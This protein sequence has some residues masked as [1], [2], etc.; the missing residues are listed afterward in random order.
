MVTPSPL[1]KF[2]WEPTTYLRRFLWA[3]PLSKEIP[4]TPPPLTPFPLS[5]K[6][7]IGMLIGI[8]RGT[9][10]LS[11]EIPMPPSRPTP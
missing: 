3:F 5:K 6:I 8:P 9:P 11:K 4:I 2:L 10:F 1:R 7:L